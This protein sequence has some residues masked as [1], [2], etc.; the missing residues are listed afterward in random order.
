MI[1]MPVEGIEEGT[2]VLTLDSPVFLAPLTVNPND[3]I[4]VVFNTT[5]TNEIDLLLKSS[6]ATVK[7]F[8]GDAALVK[9]DNTNFATQ[10]KTFTLTDSLT[11]DQLEFSGT[12]DAEKNIQITNI[13]IER[14][15]F[16]SW[17]FDVGAYTKDL[18]SLNPINY[19]LDVLDTGTGMTVLTQSA[20]V[21]SYTLNKFSYTPLIE[22]ERVILYYESGGKPL[23]YSL[24]WTNI[25]R[26]LDN[27]TSK[28]LS[29][30]DRV[31]VDEESIIT[32]ETW[33]KF[34]NLLKNTSQTVSNFISITIV[35]IYSVK[36][37]NQMKYQTQI[38]LSR[39]YSYSQYLVSNEIV[40][41]Q[42][43][44]GTYT[45]NYTQPEIG[46]SIS[47]S[48]VVSTFLLYVL[49][50]TARN[51]YFSAYSGTGLSLTSYILYINSTRYEWGGPISVLGDYV[52]VSV[53]DYYNNSAYSATLAS[54]N[55]EWYNLL[56]DVHS[57]KIV[58]LMRESTLVQ[59]CNGGAHWD[60][61]VMAGEI[62]EYVLL[63]GTYTLN[64]TNDELDTDVSVNLTVNSA[65]LYTLNTSFYPVYIGIFSNS[66]I[67]I[68][69]GA[70]RLYLDGVRVSWPGPVEVLGDVH[71]V[72]ALDY[73]GFVLFQ[74]NV[75]LASCTEYNLFVNLWT[76]IFENNFSQGIRFD[77]YK[78]N[79][80]LQTR[81]VGSKDSFLFQ[82]ADGTYTID[83]YYLNGTHTWE[84]TR[85]IVLN[86]TTDSKLQSFGIYSEN[87][88][89]DLK[90]TIKD[91]L[92]I[93]YVIAV[94]FATI[95]GL[96]IIKTRNDLAE[97]ERQHLRP[98]KQGRARNATALGEVD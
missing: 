22:G 29:T 58:N 42:L 90:P 46:T 93:L 6:G 1:G 34:G 43:F 94:V 92:L 37:Q 33:D 47:V 48:L 61:Y 14:P 81:E 36:I 66:L 11:I 21:T 13:V 9:Q 77:I 85:T 41:F 26:T 54:I 19:T 91:Y 64:Y 16:P 35:D 44:A 82:F 72:T 40:E 98:P 28:F 88:S 25:T 2:V 75:H 57:F 73:G 55:G 96:Y 49:N 20:N 97:S 74:Q 84:P 87:V 60:K 52:N 23:D 76:Q 59:V 50:T 63:A 31:M 17:S 32:I 12:F 5:N 65:M 30:T 80:L 67:G 39:N 8:A 38:T 79:L 4:T 18:V 56:L 62:V 45:L 71:N 68:E 24:F 89:I 15:T 53:V 7:S 10:T 51:L 78:G 3:R 86:A 27:V 69:S 83:T 70:V 95:L